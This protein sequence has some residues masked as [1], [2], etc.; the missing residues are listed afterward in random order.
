MRNLF[1]ILW[2]LITLMV[3]ILLVKNSFNHNNDEF[4]PG[5]EKASDYRSLKELQKQ[6]EKNI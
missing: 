4:K 5:Y 2:G 6:Y 3:C 1:N